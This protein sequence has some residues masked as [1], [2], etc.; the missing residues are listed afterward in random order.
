[1]ASASTNLEPS[2]ALSSVSSKLLG[3]VPHMQSAIASMAHYDER[4][5]GTERPCF[6]HWTRAHSAAFVLE[7]IITAAV[8]SSDCLLYPAPSRSS[9]CLNM[10][11]DYIVVGS[12]LSGTVISHRL[13]EQD[14]T[15]KSLMVEASLGLMPGELLLKIQA[16]S[17]RTQ[18]TCSAKHMTGT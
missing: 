18:L 15:W 3:V 10:L 5:E 8:N 17:G 1:M 2:S 11:W 13:L 16:L 7:M 4:H 14:S 12:G 6:F 9:F